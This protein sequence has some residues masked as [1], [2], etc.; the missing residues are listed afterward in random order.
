MG[1]ADFFTLLLC[2]ATSVE[3]VHTE[4]DVAIHIAI[5][6]QPQ[7]QKLLLLVTVELPIKILVSAITDPTKSPQ[8]TV[9]LPAFSTA[10]VVA[11]MASF[12]HLL[13]PHSFM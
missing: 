4:D 8:I 3:T 7:E 13:L 1:V 10:T 12:M 2:R 5:T 6:H 11:T 9:N